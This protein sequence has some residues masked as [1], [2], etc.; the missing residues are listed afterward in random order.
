MLKN[1]YGGDLV[2]RSQAELN[3]IL[4]AHERYALYQGGQRAQLAHADLSGLN[5]AN[6]KLM[7][8]DFSGAALVGANLYGSNL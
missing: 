5:L 1:L 4:A 6:R 2:A 3:T 8:A 7:E